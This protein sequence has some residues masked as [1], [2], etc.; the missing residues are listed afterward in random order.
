MKRDNETQC[1]VDNEQASCSHSFDFTLVDDDLVMKLISNLDESKATGSDDISIRLLKEA[2]PGI[3]PWITRFINLSLSTGVFPDE[4]KHAKICPLF[5][6]G[7]C[8]IC[9][10]YRPISILCAVI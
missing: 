2:N 1:I 7:D 10:N 6:K 9:G 5:K 4:W 3:V 8:S